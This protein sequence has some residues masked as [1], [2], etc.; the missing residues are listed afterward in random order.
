MR[1]VF[2]A[3][4]ATVLAGPVAAQSPPA[5]PALPQ[6]AALTEAIRSRDAEF[7]AVFF[8]GCDPARVEAMLT[9]DFEMFHDKGGMIAD[10][11][12]GFVADYARSCEEKKAPDAWRSRR[13]LVAGSLK[14]EPIPG[15]GAFEEGDH[16][17]YERRGDGP[18]KL[19][20]KAHFVQVWR[21]APD[22]W[23]LARVL[24]YSH[25]AVE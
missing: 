17:F 10:G 1:I 24:S 19:V 25:Q 22:G 4:A 5:A 16:L 14:V 13:E 3:L 6:G 18:E 11:A 12:T 21:L 9:P 15:Y 8:T 7:F 20:G 2:A 23:R